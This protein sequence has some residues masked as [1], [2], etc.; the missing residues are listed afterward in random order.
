M[1]DGLGVYQGAKIVESRLTQKSLLDLLC[2]LLGILSGFRF[3][4]LRSYL[5]IIEDPL[6][7]SRFVESFNKGAFIFNSFSF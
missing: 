5:L 6:I 2:L 3:L 4:L 7:W 1:V